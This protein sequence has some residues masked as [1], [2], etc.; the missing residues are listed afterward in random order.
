MDTPLTDQPWQ[1]PRSLAR[2]CTLSFL[3]Q[4][5]MSLLYFGGLLGCLSMRGL[6]LEAIEEQLQKGF[7]LFLPEADPQM[8]HRSAVLMYEH[9]LA[10]T[11]V[12]LARTVVRFLGTL[13]M[14]QGHRDGFHVY[15]TAQ[16]LGILVPILIGGRELFTFFGLLMAL[17]WCF[18]YWTQ[19]RLMR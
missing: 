6:P 7:T 8:I 16:L 14:W 12:L 17:N 15:T 18:L 4:G 1:R 10:L 11:A 13:R 9:G 2:L 5:V 3:D 19:R